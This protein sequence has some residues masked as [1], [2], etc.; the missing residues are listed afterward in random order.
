MRMTNL[1][2]KVR[3]TPMQKM[4]FTPSQIP[5]RSQNKKIEIRNGKEFCKKTGK[6]VYRT[7]GK[8]PY[9]LENDKSEDVSYYDTGIIYLAFLRRMVQ[10]ASGIE[11]FDNTL[12]EM[13]RSETRKFLLQ[14]ELS[15]YGY[16]EFQYQHE[17]KKRLYEKRFTKFIKTKDKQYSLIKLNDIC[18]YIER[19]L[20]D[21]KTE[22]NNWQKDKW[23]K[24]N[25]FYKGVMEATRGVAGE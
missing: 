21:M 22:I 9:I 1:K 23:S 12:T 4:L 17:G 20:N 24:D 10:D 2:T 16:Q 11:L 25:P 3:K 19:D 7:K 8:R 13:E 15:E 18:K 5:S 14:G 6:R